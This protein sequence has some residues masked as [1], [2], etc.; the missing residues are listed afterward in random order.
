MTAFDSAENQVIYKW[1]M[2]F[3]QISCTGKIAPA[4]KRTKFESELYDITIV[5]VQ[6]DVILVCAI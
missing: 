6:T 3:F 2:N 4:G 1:Y 5:F